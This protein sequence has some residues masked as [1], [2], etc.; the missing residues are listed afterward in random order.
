MQ[1]NEHMLKFRIY[2]EDTDAQGIV[3]H[4][5]YLRFFERGR[6]ECLLTLGV[7]ID[8]VVQPDRRMVVHEVRMKFRKPAFLGNDIEV[9]TSMNRASEYRLNFNQRIRRTGETDPLVTGEVD[10]VA[11][12]R[13]G[14]LR[15]LPSIFDGI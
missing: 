15:E 7:P 1:N 2:L 13:H 6:S 9:L 3:Y 11:I 10:I 8:H 12:D 4:G 14:N 5:S